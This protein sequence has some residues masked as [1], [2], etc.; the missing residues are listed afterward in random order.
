VGKAAGRLAEMDRLLRDKGYIHVLFI[1][2][3]KVQALGRENKDGLVSEYLEQYGLEAVYIS[4]RLA[5]LGLASDRIEALYHDMV[6]LSLRGHEL[7]G[8][9]IGEELARRLGE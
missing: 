6:H 2:P 8:Q 5:G 7:W 4:D 3:Q 9:I 1:T